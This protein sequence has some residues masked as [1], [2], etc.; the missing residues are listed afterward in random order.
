MIYKPADCKQTQSI[1]R[2]SLG[3]LL[4]AAKLHLTYQLP[5]KRIYA[6]I[7]QILFYRID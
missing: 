5:L 4:I 3:P 6:S 2:Y 7:V 1:D